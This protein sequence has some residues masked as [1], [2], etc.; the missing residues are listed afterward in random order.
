MSDPYAAFADPYNGQ[1]PQQEDPYA[2]F[3]EPYGS[4]AV[5][6]GEATAD[7]AL[8]FG[9]GFNQTLDTMLF[10]PAR[11]VRDLRE[12]AVDIAETVGGPAARAGVQS[13]LPI[14]PDFIT[15]DNQIS[16]FLR[17]DNEAKSGV[18]RAAKGAG[19]A[20]AT[21]APAAAFTMGT[22]PLIA[23]GT[24][25]AMTA[26]GQ[27]LNRL[28]QSIQKAPKSVAAGEFVASAGAGAGQQIA[29]DQGAGRGGQT[30]AALVGA[31]LPGVVASTSPVAFVGRQV[32]SRLS[33]ERAIEQSTRRAAQAIQTTLDNTP[34]TAAREADEIAKV[35]PGLDLTIGERSQN[36][37]L[38][39]LQQDLVETAPSNVAA[40][41]TSRRA[42]NER[43]ALDALARED[44]LAAR[45]AQV[46]RGFAGSSATDRAGQTIAQRADALDATNRQAVERVEQEIQDRLS[47]TLRPADRVAQGERLRELTET[48]RNTTRARMGVEAETRGLNDPANAVPFAQ[49]RDDILTAYRGASEFR[50]NRNVG[51]PD[52]TPEIQNIMDAADEQ[53]FPGLME[54]RSRLSGELSDLNRSPAPQNASQ[55]RGLASALRALDDFIDTA[56]Q[57]ATSPGRAQAYREFRRIYR[58]Q[59]AERF[60]QGAG[61]RVLRRRGNREFTTRDEEVAAA[62][63][64]SR[65]ES[66]L[67]EF[68]AI[69]TDPNLPQG[70]SG[71]ASRILRDAASDAAYSASLDSGG[72]LSASKLQSWVNRHDPVIRQVFGTN[73]PFADAL[74]SVRQIEARRDALANRRDA[75]HRNT[76]RQAVQ[77][78]GGDGATPDEFIDRVLA[79][80]QFRRQVLRNPASAA[81]SEAGWRSVAWER[82]RA[83]DDPLATFN[84]NEAGFRAL[85]GPE[86]FRTAGLIVKAIERTRSVVSPIGSA[87]QA[88]RMVDQV[89]NAL[90]MGLN[91]LSS[92]VFAVQSGRTSARYMGTEI[93]SR[94]LRGYSQRQTDRILTEALLDPELGRRLAQ[95]INRPRDP[96]R[97]RRLYTYLATIPILPDVEDE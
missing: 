52:P 32:A 41:E 55:R 49:A 26:A 70:V 90:N 75:W 43:R 30:A 84:T 28:A 87:G 10:G 42:A 6:I 27:V 34:P 85:M 11:L 61:Q 59:F 77:D 58:E 67:R 50:T 37:A 56:D 38:L 92:R 66:S 24:R 23:Q 73:H 12:G 18:G 93:A 48:A 83:S 16:R 76:V 7:A 78:M 33:P 9:Q 63:F 15:E 2:A 21:D 95:S 36:P 29:A 65:N 46:V 71:E 69:F 40:F 20:V 89:E 19:R 47:Q 39:K 62:F 22:A 81:I 53:P 82:L 79:N 72:R 54:V 51:T 14:V 5:G 31:T 97:L 80:P 45:R 88:F 8:Q 74:Q 94:I 86:A 35:V 57:F 96:R 68:A 13:A 64:R 17:R 1:T 44:D 4:S 60:L 25:T 3:S 91:Q